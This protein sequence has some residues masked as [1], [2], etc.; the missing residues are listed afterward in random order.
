M[1]KS[2]CE[3][4]LITQ[5]NR[6][7]RSK[8]ID[9]LNG[10]LLGKILLFALPV[11]ASGILQ[12]LFN[13]TDMAVV[14]RFAGSQSLA[15][16]GGNGSVINLLIT[17]FI[18][19]SIGANVV[20]A[21]YIGQNKK[22]KV[23]EA[24]H[25]TMSIAIVSGF[26]L[27][28]SGQFIA[29]PILL[30]MGAP[31]DV[32]D[33]ATLYLKIYFLGMPFI[34]IY[35]FGSA[36]LRSVG[37]TRRPLYALLVSG[38]INVGLNMVLVIVFKLDVAGVAI[39]TSLANGVSAGI[40]VYYLINEDS[41]IKLSLRELSLNKD[42]MARIFKIGAPAGI[43]GMVFSISNV[44][45]QSAINGFG[46]YA[47][48]GSAAAVNFEIFTYFVTNSF[49]QAAVTFTSQ[50]FGAQKYQRCKSIFRICICMGL[51]FTFIMNQSF[52]H[53]RYFFIDFYTSDSKVV[54]YAIIRMLEVELFTSIPVFYEVGAGALRGIGHSLLP[55][56]LTTIG[57][58]LFR[59]FWV[60][61]I[62]KDV[63]KFSK[64]MSVYP[65]TW[66]ITTVLVMFFYYRVRKK[67]F[68][69]QRVS[70]DSSNI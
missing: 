37:D 16:V 52:I 44:C 53:W 4:V 66:I 3:E 33:L 38:F 39:A 65:I 27:L 34:M 63:S 60:F 70:I 50:N 11:A 42:H 17:L 31:G 67:E 24:V 20:I 21:N 10:P 6:K 2:K 1:C 68:Y 7:V 49:A 23:H 59:I 9:M 69:R 25:T 32:I 56:I 55:A 46:S 43:Q 48:A 64:L 62:F 54:H 45:I 29:R 41:D 47:V 30:L 40:V 28:V 57:S 51:V 5:S 18:G 36:V 8:Q 61:T 22:E 13:S 58:C 26:V 14:G 12:Q 19:L 35:N 15:A